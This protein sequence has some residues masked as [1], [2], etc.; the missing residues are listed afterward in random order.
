MNTG[1]LAPDLPKFFFSE[2]YDQREIKGDS[3]K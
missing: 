2:S 3:G 1:N